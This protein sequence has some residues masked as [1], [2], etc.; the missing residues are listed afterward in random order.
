MEKLPATC[1]NEVFRTQKE[2][3][4]RGAGER[5]LPWSC[6]G[7]KTGPHNLINLPLELQSVEDY[8]TDYS[9]Y[10][11]CKDDVASMCADVEPGDNRE[12]E[13][14]VRCLSRECTSWFFIHTAS[15]HNGLFSITS[16][17]MQGT[18]R[19]SVSPMCSVELARQEKET[20]ADL[21]LSL[22]LFNKCQADYKVCC[23][24]CGPYARR[25]QS[26]R[27]FF[28]SCAYMLARARTHTHTHIRTHAHIHTHT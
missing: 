8:R 10:T 12:L 13:C 5:S 16:L 26:R 2:V 11:A 28:C 20:G 23:M 7:R 17:S 15:D 21:R 22:K 19:Y 1:K 6:S 9:L 4:N 14:L 27:R 18:K 25:L 24:E 3:R